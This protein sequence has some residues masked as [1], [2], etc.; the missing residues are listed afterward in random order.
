MVHVPHGPN[1]RQ[2]STGPQCAHFRAPTPPISASCEKYMA[3]GNS[4]RESSLSSRSCPR[5]C[6]NSFASPITPSPWNSKHGFE[7]SQHGLRGM[8]SHQLCTL[9]FLCHQLMLSVTQ[10]SSYLAST[11]VVTVEAAPSRDQCTEGPV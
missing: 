11:G 7:F 9:A 10:T 6:D 8:E 4:A 2:P 3:L 5:V 1:H